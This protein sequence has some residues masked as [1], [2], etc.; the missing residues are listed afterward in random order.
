MAIAFKKFKR[1][2]SQIKELGTVK[3]LAGKGGKVKFLRKNFKN[4]AKSV[5]LILE[6]K[7]GASAV[8][9]CSVPLSAMLRDSEITMS[10]LIGLQVIEFPHKDKIDEKTGEPVL[11]NVIALPQDGGVQEFNLNDLQAEQLELA[12]E[13]LPDELV[14][15]E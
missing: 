12:K 11:V 14:T 15:F 6:R 5:A 13:F 1:D 3:S 8:I 7:D 9:P 4:K 10:Q 2:A